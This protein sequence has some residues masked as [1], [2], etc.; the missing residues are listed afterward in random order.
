MPKHPSPGKIKTH[1]IYTVWEA[2]EVLGLHRQ[3]VLRWIKSKKLKA[4]C[5]FKPWLIQGLDLKT[6]LKVRRTNGKRPSK[7][8]EIYCLPCRAPKEPAGKMAEYSQKTATTGTLAGICP[9][10][11]RLIHRFIKRDQLPKI[12]LHLDVTYTKAN[13]RIVG[14]ALPPVT[15]NLMDKELS[16]GKAQS[17]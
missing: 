7:I 2:A 12:Q 15:V 14:P 11:N 6:F 4:D 13:A 9:D 5:S 8:N 16:H 1:M 17:L 3:T 10:C